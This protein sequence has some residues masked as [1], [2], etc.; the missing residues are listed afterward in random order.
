MPAAHAV[1][2][3]CKCE[4][5]LERDVDGVLMD[6]WL[7]PVHVNRVQEECSRHKGFASNDLAGHLF[8]LTLTDDGPNQRAGADK[9]WKLRADSQENGPSNDLIAG[10]L[11]TLPLSNI[12]TA[13]AVS[14]C[15]IPTQHNHQF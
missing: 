8:G 14:S 3:Q 15:M 10:S 13:S 2:K 1:F 7:M 4:E 9:L 6:T 5:C 12:L 11:T